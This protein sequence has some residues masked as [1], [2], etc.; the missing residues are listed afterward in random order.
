VTE[1]SGGEITVLAIDEHA[2]AQQ[3]LSV[4]CVVELFAHEIICSG[5]VVCPALF[6]QLLGCRSF[7]LVQVEQGSEWQLSFS[8]RRWADFSSSLYRLRKGLRIDGTDAGRFREV[9][10]EGARRM[11][12]VIF[13]SCVFASKVENDGGTAGVFG[14]EVGDIPDDSI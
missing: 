8:I 9:F 4:Y 1:E 6:G 2:R 5:V 11:N 13:F 12:G 14:K 10:F 3:N 7:H